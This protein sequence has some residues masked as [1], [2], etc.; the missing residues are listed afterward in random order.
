[1]NVAVINYFQ[2]LPKLRIRIAVSVHKLIPGETTFADDHLR[3]VSIV[4][5]P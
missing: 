2:R 1:M 5:R 4:I 3:A